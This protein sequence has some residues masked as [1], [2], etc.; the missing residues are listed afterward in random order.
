MAGKVRMTRQPHFRAVIILIVAI[1]FAGVATSQDAVRPQVE[2]ERLGRRMDEMSIVRP[3][4]LF[5]TRGKNFSWHIEMPACG[6]W[7][8][9]K[10]GMTGDEV[11]NLPGK[12]DCVEEQGQSTRWY[13]NKLKTTGGWVFFDRQSRKVLEWQTF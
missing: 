1:Q 12:P 4:P 7:S 6:K 8:S 13:W 10:L 5:D 11:Q 9:L 2:L 3:V